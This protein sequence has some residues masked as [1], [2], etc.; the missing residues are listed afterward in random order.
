[1]GA[2]DE[3]L[4]LPDDSH[5]KGS[6]LDAF[7]SLPEDA[8]EPD[9]DQVKAV[10]SVMKPEEATQ[11]LQAAPPDKAKGM[12]A[13]ILGQ[14]EADKK[15]NDP[16]LQRAGNE[17]LNMLNDPG[18]FAAAL[19]GAGANYIP[20]AEG[21]AGVAGKAL[22]KQVLAHSAEAGAMGAAQGAANAYAAGQPV[23]PAA[24]IDSGV[25]AVV[26]AVTGLA[27]GVPPL[28]RKAG[29][30]LSDKGT[31]AR[32]AL[33]L[34]K[35]SAGDLAE[36]YGLDNVTAHAGELL[37]K[38]SPSPMRGMSAKD[39]AAE[40]ARQ[41]E[42]SG[43]NL[44]QLRDNI[45]ATALNP[46]TPSAGPLM[47]GQPGDLEQ[48]REKVLQGL[49]A[50]A[51]GE[52][53]ANAGVRSKRAEL[54]RI[55]KEYQGAPDV[56]SASGAVAPGAEPASFESFRDLGARKSEAQE[57]ARKA[58]IAGAVGDT[59]AAQAAGV[60]GSL[61]RKAEDSIVSRAPE[62]IA[63]SFAGEKQ[64]Y[65]ELAML[66]DL[67]TD[68]AEA[69]LNTG[70]LGGIV[71]GAAASGIAGGIAG[72]AAAYSAGENPLYGAAVGTGAGALAGF[73]LNGGATR[74]AVRQALGSRGED[75]GA[76]ILKATGRRMSGVSDMHLP[77]T[78]AGEN[79]TVT[80]VLPGRMAGSAAAQSAPKH[81]P[82]ASFEQALSANPQAFGSYAP[83]L[84]Q[85]ALKG[86]LHD[87][88]EELFD[89]DPEF[90]KLHAQVMYGD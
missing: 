14:E 53:G 77:G 87:K 1:M 30:W 83:E 55:A 41:Q 42:F 26:P 75:M 31:E 49:L 7:K 32:N 18:K 37:E 50:A 51:G 25:S 48:E 27:R 86:E 39:H 33:L 72:G 84:Q 24:L 13:R 38:Y 60:E 20:G 74:T 79:S 47:P 64:R 4:Q 89:R 61:L 46:G 70:G 40:I 90:R 67:L 6:A 2:L 36:Q 80:G 52:T 44:S 45:D 9:P 78:R 59:A 63:K 82:E 65:G 66:R 56:V 58:S 81:S 71:T 88:I 23:G 69:E 28:L 19:F 22:A 76:N 68:R 17:Y 5:D 3:F 85:A 35:R 73:G 8:A 62:P 15:L 11:I 16:N 29:S 43:S 54:Q 21:T 10:A 57:F 34:T 12:L